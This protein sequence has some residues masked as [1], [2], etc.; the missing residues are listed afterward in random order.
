MIE[1]S[2]IVG[3][4]RPFTQASLKTLS[5][6]GA[7][8]VIVIHPLDIPGDEADALT[9]HRHSLVLPGGA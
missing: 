1:A 8:V 7:R 4:N 2:D 3:G 6:L 9:I 5:S